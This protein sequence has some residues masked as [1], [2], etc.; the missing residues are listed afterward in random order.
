MFK[1]ASDYHRGY[2][3]KTGVLDTVKMNRY[4]ITD[5]IFKK[6]TIVPE[7]KN[8]GFI[9]YLDM[10]GS[11]ASYIYQTI[12][13]LLLLTHFTKQIGVPF[14]VYGFT[15][16]FGK[17]KVANSNMTPEEVGYS[18]LWSD[19]CILL[20]LF[21]SE[22]TRPHMVKMSGLLL[23]AYARNADLVIEHPDLKKL[24]EDFQSGYSWRPWQIAPYSK[25]TML[26]GTPMD[27][28]IALGV[29]LA[30][31]FRKK[32]R[33]D[34][35]NT[36]FLTD[37]ASHDMSMGPNSGEYDARQ[38]DHMNRYWPQR[39]HVTITNP[40]TNRNI[41]VRNTGG[42][43]MT[44]YLLNI[45]KEATGSSVVGYR[46]ERQ[47]KWAVIKTYEF[48]VGGKTSWNEREAIA[49]DMRD[50]SY[51][52]VTDPEG[53]DEC[54]ILG[55]KS[56]RLQESEL[57]DDLVGESKAKLRTA[58]KKSLLSHKKSRKMLTDL[59]KRVA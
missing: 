30:K 1:S 28:A 46:I 49:T 14:R 21:S 59:V 18:E 43:N 41:R 38:L 2:S 36:I 45:Y 23:M 42:M 34:I 6:V 11:M 29:P 48:L 9:M 16:Q 58:F 24:D 31:D 3:A 53:Y 51:V 20:E 25:M 40:W 54:Y 10:S 47:T 8:H 22:M 50:H 44:P 5:D 17:H 26:G 37:G 32:Y 56:L 7:G 15:N 39:D 55:D 12:E 13:Q 19:D 52:K 57:S 4:R 33:V 35:L 27:G